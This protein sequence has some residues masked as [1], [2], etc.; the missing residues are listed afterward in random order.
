MHS[1]EGGHRRVN[2][3]SSRVCTML[4]SKYKRVHSDDEN[5]S[6]STGNASETVV[7]PGSVP[8]EAKQN[9]ETQSMPVLPY[10]SVSVAP[11]VPEY[12]MTVRTTIYHLDLVGYYRVEDQKRHFNCQRIYFSLLSSLRP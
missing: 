3:K 10:K 12:K 7:R 11:S 5:D 1:E 9:T 8:V 2:K 4:V 6:E